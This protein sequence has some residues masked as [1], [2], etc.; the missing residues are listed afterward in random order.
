MY[1][2]C[3]PITLWI[4]SF[5]NISHNNFVELGKQYLIAHEI[6]LLGKLCAF[7]NPVNK[8]RPPE[9]IV[10]YLKGFLPYI[11]LYLRHESFVV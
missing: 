1:A 5:S 9:Y 6:R 8:L 10:T 4:L 11:S 7:N 2:E 3:H